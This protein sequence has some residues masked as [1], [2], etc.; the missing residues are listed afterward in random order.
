VEVAEIVIR[1]TENQ[2]VN[3][4]GL[5]ARN[6]LRLEAGL[7][8][9]GTDIDNNTSPM[10]AG[11]GWLLGKRGSR[12]RVGRGFLGA[13]QILVPDSHE[14]AFQPIQ[15][16]RVG[17]TGMP[18]PARENTI[19]YDVS[20]T[21][22]IGRVT[23]GSY[24]PSLQKP[25]AMGYVSIEHSTVGTPILLQL[26]DQMVPACISNMPFVDT[27]YYRY[28][29]DPNETVDEPV[30]QDPQYNTISAI[31]KDEITRSIDFYDPFD[32]D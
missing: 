10:E 24:A 15:R 25:I 23:S 22:Q 3:V 9:Y 8:L 28:V 12:R 26:H 19:I 5:G 14:G 17:I 20:G 29:P 11:Y 21:Q 7:P 32:S 18:R 27:K 6:T 13:N 30:E 31:R 16:R 2:T 1:L 4:A